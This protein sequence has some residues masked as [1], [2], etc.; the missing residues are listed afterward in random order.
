MRDLARKIIAI[1]KRGATDAIAISELATRE[2]GL[3]NRE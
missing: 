2:L 1:D 3:P